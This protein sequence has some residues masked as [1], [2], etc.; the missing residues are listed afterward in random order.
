MSILDRATKHFKDQPIT[1][2]TVPEWADENGDPTI[3]YSTPFTMKERQTLYK[4]ADGDDLEFMIRLVIMKALDSDGK[5]LFD[6]TDK[7]TFENSVDPNVIMRI[8]AQM[9]KTPSIGD[10]EGN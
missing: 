9:S 1:E 2:V 8:A 7:K 5:K 3:I 4:F 10:I 6:L